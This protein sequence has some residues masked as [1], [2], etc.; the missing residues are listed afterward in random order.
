MESRYTRDTVQSNIPPGAI[1]VALVAG[2]VNKRLL[3]MTEDTPLM[4]RADVSLPANL[5][6]DSDVIIVPLLTHR[7]IRDKRCPA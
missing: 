3:V 1:N 7:S 5:R 2:G 4:Y 6:L